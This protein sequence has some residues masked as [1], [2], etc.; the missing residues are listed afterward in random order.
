MRG[1]VMIAVGAGAG[2]GEGDHPVLIGVGGGPGTTHQG[3][4]NIEECAHPHHY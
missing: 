2:A 4:K 3:G 1:D